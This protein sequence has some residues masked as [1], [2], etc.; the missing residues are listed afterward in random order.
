MRRWSAAP[1]LALLL[2]VAAPAA[3]QSL[4]GQVYRAGLRTSDGVRVTLYRYRPAGG[5]AAGGTLLLFPDVGMTHRAFDAGGAGLA[6]YLQRRG[7][8]VFVL[9]YRGSGYS[10][11]PWGGYDF[12]DL[13]EK[14]AEAALAAVLR[15]RPRVH[16]GG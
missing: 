7:V 9:E 4:P 3:A 14:D 8:E 16:L 6:R 2:T 5:G 12:D 13:V 11:V 10:D 1:L 15:E